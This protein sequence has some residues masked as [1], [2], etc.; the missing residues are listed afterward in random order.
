LFFVA[1]GVMWLGY[2]TFAYSLSQIRGCNAGFLAMA[3]PG[4]TTPVCNPDTGG[5]STGTT[6]TPTTPGNCPSGQVFNLD[7]GTCVKQPTKP[8][9]AGYVLFNG[10]CIQYVPGEGGVSHG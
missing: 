3:W 7:T 5:S 6:K 9:P 1:A 10:Q 2:T 4:K 8:C